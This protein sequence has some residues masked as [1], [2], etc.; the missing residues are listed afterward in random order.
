MGVNKT[1]EFRL[2]VGDKDLYDNI[3]PYCISNL[4]Q[5]IASLHAEEL[6]VGYE[7][8]N[9]KKLA[10]IIA[11]NKISIIDHSKLTNIVKVKTWPLPNG[12]FDFDREYLLFNENDELIAK[13]TSKWLVY[14]LKRN[15][16][17][18]SKGIMENIEFD[19]IKNYNEPFNKI[20]YG[21]LNDYS[22]IYDKKIMFSDLDHYGHMN[23]AKY[24]IILS[25]TLKLN[26]DE[27]IVEV[28]VDYLNQGYLDDVISIFVKKE[29]NE[30][31]IVGKNQDKI[32]FVIKTKIKA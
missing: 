19:T 11:R 4:F 12:R 5:E 26:K 8:M 1:L 7:V 28:Q 23:N 32:I 27:L 14:D 6:G 16:L 29:N 31:Y 25:D 3:T 24:L 13:G 21:N 2:T 17:C 15:F 10:W 20:N 30:Y 9:E 22:F 18:S